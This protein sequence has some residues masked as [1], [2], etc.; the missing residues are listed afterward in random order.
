LCEAFHL[1]RYLRDS[2]AISTLSRSPRSAVVLVKT[3]RHGADD[4]ARSL[5]HVLLYTDTVPQKRELLTLN[6]FVFIA[7]MLFVCDKKGIRLVKC[8]ALTT[9]ESSLLVIQPNL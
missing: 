3:L 9:P 7:F 8:P 2:G 5:T 1:G 6:G 4:V